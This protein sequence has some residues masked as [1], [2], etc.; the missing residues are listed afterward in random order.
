M[1]V[2][3]RAASQMALSW[4]CGTAGARL[5]AFYQRPAD[6]LM[7]QLFEPLFSSEVSLRD[8]W[9]YPICTFCT[10]RRAS[11]GRGRSAHVRTLGADTGQKAGSA[12]LVSPQSH[13]PR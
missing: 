11:P 10:L 2:V 9:F 1:A 6:L 3:S 4:L 8:P 7:Q 12:S 13:G 5:G